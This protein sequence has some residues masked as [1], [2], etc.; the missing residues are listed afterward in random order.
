[1]EKIKFAIT[2]KGNQISNTLMQKMKT[3]LLDFHLEYD[4]NQPDIVVS[5]GGMERFSTRF[6]AI[7]TDLT[8]RLLLGFIPAI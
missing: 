2:S 4:E 8:R 7:E 1:M 6:T 5:V 3:Y